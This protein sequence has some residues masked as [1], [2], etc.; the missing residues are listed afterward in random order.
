LPAVVCGSGVP[1]SSLAAMAAKG[2]PHG[3]LPDA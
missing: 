1:G 3:P 2:I